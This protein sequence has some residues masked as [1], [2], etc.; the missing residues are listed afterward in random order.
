MDKYVVSR[1]LAEK[2]RDAGYPQYNSHFYWMQGFDEPVKA[3]KTGEGILDDFAAALSDELLEQL[4]KEYKRKELV[5]S[6]GED[7]EKTYAGY[8]ERDN[9]GYYT[10]DDNFYRDCFDADKPADALAQLWLWCVENGYIQTEV[11]G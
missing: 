5:I 3:Y 2:L 4:P 1:E 11:K 7:T 9:Y 8:A 10:L 6:C